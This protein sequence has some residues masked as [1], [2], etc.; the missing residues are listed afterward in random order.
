MKT[1]LLIGLGRFGRHCAIRLHEL[2]HQIMAVDINERRVQEIIP[3]VTNVLIGDSTR[4]DFVQSLGVSDYDLCFVAI[5]DDFQSSLETTSLLKE[6]G[7]KK[8]ISRASRDVHAKFL[9]RNGADQ[10]VYPEKQ[11]AEWSADRYSSDLIL[12]YFSMGEGYA[13]MEIQM[14]ASWIGRTISELDIRKKYQINI[15]AVRRNGR[16]NMQ[17]LPDTVF[18]GDETLLVLGK[19]QHVQKS[20]ER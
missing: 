6:L 7:A 15:L 19:E 11:V 2:G 20:L 4:A 13:V 18:N 1:V 8:V 17:I 5:G 16:L 9:L 12:D 14:P 3:Y 10:V